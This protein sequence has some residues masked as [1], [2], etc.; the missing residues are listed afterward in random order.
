MARIRL[1]VM[2]VALLALPGWALAGGWALTSFDEL[3]SDLEAGASYDLTY[4]VFQHGVTPVD[5]G[6]SEVRVIDGNG[7]VTTFA[8]TRLPER[9][10]YAVTVTF[11]ESGLWTWEVTQGEFGTHPMGP[12]SVSPGVAATATTASPLAWLLPLA[13]AI[14][15][16]LVA[17][18]TVNLARQRR[19]PRPIRAD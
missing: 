14:T 13:L 15:I 9:G 12:I 5:V 6:Q 4:T 7:E 1:L 18:Q 2:T 3:P 10:R 19:R 11:P 17:V 16:G 8:A